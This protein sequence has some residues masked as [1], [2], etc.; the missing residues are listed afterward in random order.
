MK[1]SETGQC[2]SLRE[3]EMEVEAEMRAWGRQRLQEK[4]QAQADQHGR[5][6][7][8]RLPPDVARPPATPDPA[9]HRRG[10]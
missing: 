8:P 10:N 7:P 1:S 4:L 6:F 2:R 3:I 5:V 9:H